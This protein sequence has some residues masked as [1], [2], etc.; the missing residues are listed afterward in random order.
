[1]LGSSRWNTTDCNFWE[2]SLDQILRVDLNNRLDYCR[3]LDLRAE[4]CPV[5]DKW[6]LCKVKI[7]AQYFCSKNSVFQEVGK[8][9]QIIRGDSRVLQGGMKFQ[10]LSIPFSQ[11]LLTWKIWG[12][13]EIHISNNDWVV[14]KFHLIFQGETPAVFESRLE[15]GLWCKVRQGDVRVLGLVTSTSEWLGP[16]IDSFQCIQIFTEKYLENEFE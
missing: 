15:P 13:F 10:W 7:S 6:W 2:Q 12:Q 8:G 1:M 11:D 16:R 3:L 14:E 4:L 9:P 5:V